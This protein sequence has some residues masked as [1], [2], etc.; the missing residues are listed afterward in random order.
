MCLSLDVDILQTRLESLEKKGQQI[1]VI[2][3]LL[4]KKEDKLRNEKSNINSS[5]EATISSRRECLFL[6]FLAVLKFGEQK[7]IFSKKKSHH[8][9]K[10]AF[11]CSEEYK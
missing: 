9:P 6:L 7:N 3:K 4:K 2:K 11:P 1:L 10:S 5:S 8:S